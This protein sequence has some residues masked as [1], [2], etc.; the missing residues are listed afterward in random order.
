MLRHQ[1]FQ[2]A[3][4][5]EIHYLHITSVKRVLSYGF[6][7]FAYGKSPHSGSVAKSG[8]S[9]RYYGIDAVVVSMVSYISRCCCTSPPPSL[10]AIGCFGVVMNFAVHFIRD[11]FLFF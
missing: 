4:L 6:Y 2:D 5:V 7:I 1:S 11:I 10:P 3:V 9:D 8:V